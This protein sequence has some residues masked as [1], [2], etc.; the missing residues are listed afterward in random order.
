MRML[1]EAPCSKVW[2]IMLQLNPKGAHFLQ[3]DIAHFDNAFFRISDKEASVS[4]LCLPFHVFQSTF[5]F[6]RISS[7]TEMVH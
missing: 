6:I 7:L 4:V 5:L 1:P 2:L 3:D